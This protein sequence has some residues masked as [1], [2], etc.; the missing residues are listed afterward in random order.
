MARYGTDLVQ[1]IPSPTAAWLTAPVEGPVKA[2]LQKSDQYGRQLC[3]EN[4]GA[5]F[6]YQGHG[7]TLMPVQGRFKQLRSWN[8]GTPLEKPDIALYPSPGISTSAEW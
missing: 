4:D 7:T 8:F 6:L 3:P 5:E 2:S 1:G